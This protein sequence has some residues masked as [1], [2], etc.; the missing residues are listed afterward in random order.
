MVVVPKDPHI[1]QTKITLLDIQPPVWRRVQVP[2]DF[3]L[4]SLHDVIQAVMGW[5]DYHIHEFEIG[6]RVYG[7]A[8]VEGIDGFASRV[9]NDKTHYLH[10]LIEHGV[11]RFLYTYDLGDDWHHEI[12]IEEVLTPQT[13][14]AYPVFIDGER[15]CPPDD[16][17]GPPGFDEF[18]EAMDDEDH[19][20]HEHL[21]E[22]Y[23]NKPFDP[24]EMELD[25]VEA[26]LSQ[27]R[28]ETRKPPRKRKP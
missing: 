14:V 12:E 18:L 16:C 2:D 17:G 19:P 5:L 24:E 25:A 23:G 27:I 8:D 4:R 7:E 6:D 15:R 21:F 10:E 3:T 9:F 26:K 1:L 20:D 11:D 22:W 28:A 13:D